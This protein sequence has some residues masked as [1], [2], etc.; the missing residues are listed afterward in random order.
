MKAEAQGDPEGGYFALITGQVKAVSG[1]GSQK[2]DTKGNLKLRES[3]SS[4]CPDSV[5]RAV[6]NGKEL[7]ATVELECSCPLCSFG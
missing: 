5:S 2:C 4:F 3:H 7:E 6:E 1:A